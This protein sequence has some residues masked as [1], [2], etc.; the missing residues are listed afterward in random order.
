MSINVKTENVK[1][2]TIQ[3]HIAFENQPFNHQKPKRRRAT[4]TFNRTARRGADTV[5]L[6][7]GRNTADHRSSTKWRQRN[8][9]LL[10]HEQFT[11]AIS[12]P[13]HRPA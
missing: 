6:T 11:P 4:R 12:K 7:T 1:D 13:M 2:A 10:T 9:R 3:V 5:Q 8:K